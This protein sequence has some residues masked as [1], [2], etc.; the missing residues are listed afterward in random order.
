MR[1]R[2]A[3]MREELK[4]DFSRL[5]RAVKMLKYSLQRCKKI[6]MKTDYSLEE[7][8]RFESLTSRFAR[9]SDI[10]TQK[11]MKGVILM[12]REEA[13]TFIDR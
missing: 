10:Y 1:T 8:D 7:L 4:E 3:L 11:V 2:E 9:T 12:L 6:G 5:D 13:N